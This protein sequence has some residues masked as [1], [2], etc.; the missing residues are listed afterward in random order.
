MKKIPIEKV[1]EIFSKKNILSSYLLVEKE[2]ALAQSELKIIPK[3]SAIEI[4]KKCNIKYFNLKFFEKDLKKTKAPIVSLVNFIVKLCSE[5]SKKY[6][7]YGATTQ[8]ITQAGLALLMRKSHIQA[9]Y[10]LSDCLKTLSKLSFKFS[11]QPMIARTNGQHGMPMTFGF[12]ISEW[13]EEIL[14]FEERFEEIEK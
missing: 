6:V 8:N 10:R 11:N 4:S 7:H 12:K 14:R 9:M 1:K 3:K 13:T 5:E 2:M